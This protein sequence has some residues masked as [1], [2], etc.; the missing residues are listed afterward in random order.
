[1]T[2]K[3]SLTSPNSTECPYCKKI[4]TV[5]LEEKKNIKDTLDT[6]KIEENKYE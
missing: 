2:Y 4:C 5:S 3:L 6:I 1:M